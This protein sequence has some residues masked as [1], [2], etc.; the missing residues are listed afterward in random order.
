MKYK[1]QVSIVI[2][3]SVDIEFLE[4]ATI[5]FIQVW[6]A[7]I[8]WDKYSAIIIID[9]ENTFFLLFDLKTEKLSNCYLG[10]LKNDCWQIETD[11]KITWSRINNILGLLDL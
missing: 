2:A 10:Y 11:R 1:K 3:P 5:S 7:M 4:P 8:D 6:S 9:I